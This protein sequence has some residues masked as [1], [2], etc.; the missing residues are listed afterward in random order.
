MTDQIPAKTILRMA[1]IELKVYG[2]GE[3]YRSL[4]A[5]WN[6]AVGRE[7]VQ[8]ACREIAAR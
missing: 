1:R 8:A 5:L 6:T 2:D 7:Y 3:R 4:I